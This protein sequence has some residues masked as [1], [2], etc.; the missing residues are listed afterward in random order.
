MAHHHEG[1]AVE[2]VDQEAGLVIDRQAERAGDPSH[3][4]LGEPCLGGTCQGGEDRRVVLG[5]DEAEMTGRVL[6]AL[7]V[8]AVHLGRD[9]AHGLT[10]FNR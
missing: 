4:L 10:A 2:A 3:A 5:L 9:A 8:P 1:R 6:I 7:Q